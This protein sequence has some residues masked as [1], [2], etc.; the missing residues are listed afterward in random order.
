MSTALIMTAYSFCRKW[1]RG[2][3]MPRDLTPEVFGALDGQPQEQVRILSWY[4]DPS[5]AHRSSDNLRGDCPDDT[6]QAF[7]DGLWRELGVKS[8]LDVERAEE[9]AAKAATDAAFQATVQARLAEIEAARAEAAQ[10]DA[11][12]AKEVRDRVYQTRAERIAEKDDDREARWR[13]Q[14]DE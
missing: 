9:A 12:R 6:R 11:I 4:L 1:S 5:N 14:G 10:A 8:P 3:S 7:Y 13:G 2:R